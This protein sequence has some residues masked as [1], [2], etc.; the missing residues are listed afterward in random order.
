MI[1]S[2][3]TLASKN[4]EKETNN[5]SIDLSSKEGKAFCN[6]LFGTRNNLFLSRD[7]KPRHDEEDSYNKSLEIN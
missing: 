1:Y 2:T 6:S 7:N 5:N 4:S 3:S